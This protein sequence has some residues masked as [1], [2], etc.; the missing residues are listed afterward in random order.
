MHQEA[1]G[2]LQ[3]KCLQFL[4]LLFPDTLINWQG[5]EHVLP[6]TEMANR[7]E[8]LRENLVLT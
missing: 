2:Q 7:G 3:P 8:R 6:Q 4:V 5:E 1:E